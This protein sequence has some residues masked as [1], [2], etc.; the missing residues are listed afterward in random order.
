MSQGGMQKKQKNK[1]TTLN[2]YFPRWHTERRFS[3]SFSIKTKTA[4][5]IVETFSWWCPCWPTLTLTNRT[6]CNTDVYDIACG[7][8]LVQTVHCTP[9]VSTALRRMMNILNRRRYVRC[10]HFMN[11]LFVQIEP[12]SAAGTPQSTC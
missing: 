1:G 2:W 9:V 6:Y 11:A 7:G 5:W 3:L 10:T 4:A 8:F 12:F